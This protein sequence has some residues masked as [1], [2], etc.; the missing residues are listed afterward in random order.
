MILAEELALFRVMHR[1]KKTYTHA[2][3][4][5]G[6]IWVYGTL[7]GVLWWLVIA[8]NTL[9]M[10]VIPK[11]TT[12]MQKWYHVYHVVWFLPLI[13]VIISLANEKLGYGGDVWFV[14]SP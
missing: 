6:I 11:F 1:K 9:A 13:S 5:T 10:L 14:T 12:I 3:T 2:H 8:L 7:A 4:N